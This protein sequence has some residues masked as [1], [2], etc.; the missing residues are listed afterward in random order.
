[1]FRDF[2]A[3][4]LEKSEFDVNAERG[5]TRRTFAPLE[6]AVVAA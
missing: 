4:K 2:R 5:F 6:P 1:M 3:G